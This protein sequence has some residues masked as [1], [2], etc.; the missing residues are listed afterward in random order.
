LLQFAPI[1]VDARPTR[2]ASR[3]TERLSLDTSF[4]YIESLAQHVLEGQFA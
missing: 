3:H 2:L 1:G 4:R